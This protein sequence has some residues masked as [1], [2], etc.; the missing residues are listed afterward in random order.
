MREIDLEGIL[1]LL[2]VFLLFVFFGGEP[3]LQDGLI[4]YLNSK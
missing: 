1:F 4:N 2:F 3:D